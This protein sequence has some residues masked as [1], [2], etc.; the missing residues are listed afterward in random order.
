MNN[1]IFADAHEHAI[2]TVPEMILVYNKQATLLNIV[3]PG[4]NLPF[5]PEG[6]VGKKIDA[7]LDW[8]TYETFPDN[9]FVREIRDI[10]T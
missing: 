1:V 5:N 4:G 7:F 3:N 6:M 2:K 10:R 8:E 9:S